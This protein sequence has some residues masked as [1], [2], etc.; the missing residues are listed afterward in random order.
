MRAFGRNIWSKLKTFGLVIGRPFGKLWRALPGPMRVV[1]RNIVG[2]LVIL[3]GLVMALPGVPGPGL[4]TII[5]GLLLLDF[6]QKRAM[7]RRL[8]H[9]WLVQK[10]LQNQL[11]AKLWR[12]MRRQAKNSEVSP[13]K[14]SVSDQAD[15]A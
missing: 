11:F 2:T 6:S 1:I 8:Q 7:L 12:H 3:A 14:D 5:V 4:A 9:N 15:R 10:F 13:R